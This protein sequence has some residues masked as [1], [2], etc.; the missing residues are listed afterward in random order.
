MELSSLAPGWAW[1]R[2]GSPSQGSAGQLAAAVR[3]GSS[4]NTPTKAVFCLR[5]AMTFGFHRI[6]QKLQAHEGSAA[7]VTWRLLS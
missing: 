6:E 5:T 1:I 4:F 3:I 2:S 7:L